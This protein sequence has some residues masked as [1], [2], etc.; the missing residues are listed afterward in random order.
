MMT[1]LN[2]FTVL[3]LIFTCSSVSASDIKD[4]HRLI[5][6]Q[7]YQ[8]AYKL[9]DSIKLENEGDPAFDY[10]YALSALE[11]GHPDKAVFALERVIAN[12]PDNQAAKLDLARAYYLKGEFEKSK[13]LFK[14]VLD[15]S[16][17]NNVR[18]N[19]NSYLKRIEKF[20]AAN[21]Y[22]TTAF[23]EL[24]VGWDSNINSASDETTISL[25][26]IL[27]TLDSN[28]VDALFS[29]I[30]AS[31][32]YL[33]RINKFNS[34]FI[35]GQVKSRDNISQDYDT[36]DL[37]LR[38]GY[39]YI[40][41]KT[42]LTIP[43]SYQ[44]T[45]L[46]RENYR[47]VFSLST[48]LTQFNNKNEFNSYV[49]QYGMTTYDQRSSLNLQYMNLGFSNNMLSPSDSYINTISLFLGTEVPEDSSNK[50]NTRDYGGLAYQWG[51]VTNKGLYTRMN[52]YNFKHQAT[53][54][55]LGKKRI[56]TLANVL[57]GY[58]SQP[59]KN[60]TIDSTVGYLNNESNIGIY[61]YNRTT[62]EVVLRVDF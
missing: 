10:Y 5:E 54:Q 59:F 8:E 25:S 55:T 56:D 36:D 37:M 16:P 44:S 23:A 48:E 57:L 6:S 9:A 29:T 11:T 58:K 62:A 22:Q 28:K 14:L 45:Y 20:L 50:Q 12:Q 2:I 39:L 60:W 42:R 21:S 46:N 19:I 41:D 33:K 18:N 51:N 53:N 47:S 30:K 34:Y 1:K 13:T 40:N 3:Y 31:G 27:F 4:I 15:T 61:S 24:S 43:V 38:T 17:P 52:V 35:G 49:L 26:N 32:N 7:K